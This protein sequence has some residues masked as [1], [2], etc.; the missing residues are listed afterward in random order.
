[1]AQVMDPTTRQMTSITGAMYQYLIM[2][3]LIASGMYRYLLGAVAQSFVVIPVGGAV[4]HAE[5]LVATVTGFMVDYILIGFQICLP[6]F[7]VTLLLNAVLGVLAKVS[8]QLNMFAVGLQLKILVG[9]SVLF[10]T[11]SML[12]DAADFIFVQM[13]KMTVSFVEGMI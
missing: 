9:L 8:P 7:C 13:K 3:M 10:F 11:I 1:M 2:L 12:P 6:V 4:F 5:S